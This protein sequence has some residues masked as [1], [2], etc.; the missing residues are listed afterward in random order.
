[1]GEAVTAD[2]IDVVVK[3]FLSFVAV[4]TVVVGWFKWLRPRVKRAQQESVAIRDAILGR[5]AIY[6]SITGEE[7]VPSLPGIGMRMATVEE[8]LVALADVHVKMLDHEDRIK[9]LETGALERILT[10]ADSVAAFRAMEAVATS[11]H[12]KIPPSIPE[13][14]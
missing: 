5:D 14:P 3:A 12:D 6:D 4:A 13:K 1:M 8:A 10:R 2:E 7:R 9:Q 11:D